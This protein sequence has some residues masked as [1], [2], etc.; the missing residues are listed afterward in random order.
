MIPDRL[1]SL[2]RLR[3]GARQLILVAGRDLNDLQRV[4]PRL[5]LFNL[6]VAENGA[7]L[8]D[9]T[10]HEEQPLCDVPPSVFVERLRELEVAPLWVGRVIVATWAPNVVVPAPDALARSRVLEHCVLSVYVVL[11]IEGICVRGS[12]VA[13]ECLS[14]LLLIHP[15]TLAPMA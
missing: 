12:A 10:N 1:F 9:P 14:N 15:D 11:N 8:Y 5:D 3:G 6:V 2:E 4:M 13:I 7:L